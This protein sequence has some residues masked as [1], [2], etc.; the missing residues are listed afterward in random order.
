MAAAENRIV[1]FA[2]PRGRST[3]VISLLMVAVVIGAMAIALTYLTLPP[4]ARFALL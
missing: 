3:W 1:T 4:I 2:A